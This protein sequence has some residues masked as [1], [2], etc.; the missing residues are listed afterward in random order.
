M[1]LDVRRVSELVVAAG[2]TAILTIGYIIYTGRILGPAE[3]AN[4]S[5]GLSV[6]YLFSVALSPVTPTIARLVTR[7]AVRCDVGAVAALRRAVVRRLTIAIV[8]LAVVFLAFATPLARALH[9]RAT[10]TLL[11]SFAA[12]LL[13]ALL[14]VDRG[15]IHGL[16]RFRAHNMNTVLEAVIRAGGAFL[17]LQISRTST[18]A[19][20]SYAIALLVAEGV[21]AAMFAR[22]WRS[23]APAL[24]DWTEVT[25]LT[26]PMI[27][28]MLAIAI[29]QNADVLAVKRWFAPNEAGVY[30]AASAIARAFGVIFVPLYVLA[31]PLLTGAH[32]SG[33]PIRGLT[34]QLTGV[35]LALSTIPLLL[36]VIW[37][38]RIMTLLYGPAYAAAG[39]LVARLG[40]VA[41]IT[42][43]A[44]MLA[45]A[46]ISVADFRFLAVYG[47]GAA[48]QV[49]ALAVRHATYNEVIFALYVPQTIVLFIVAI[50]FATCSRLSSQASTKTRI[51]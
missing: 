22:E 2:I 35:F 4:F 21:I 8:V 39:P 23:V 38:E 26:L 29:F 28:L 32:D 7:S 46:L 34:L 18:A 24:V 11:I 3:Y 44:L 40:G 10:S 33:R 13:F 50:L 1:N 5:A 36:F 42:F 47:L 6:I 19:L 14:S 16:M 45:Q 12:A 41:I 9:F 37:P 49:I 43:T 51:S 31:G 48:G 15:V 25:R 17:L 27:V 20:I 30:G